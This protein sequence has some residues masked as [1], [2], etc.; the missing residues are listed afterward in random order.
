ME[1]S[2]EKDRTDTVCLCRSLA[3]NYVSLCTG[4][5]SRNSYLIHTINGNS[6]NRCSVP[7]LRY[8]LP[9]VAALPEPTAVKPENTEAPTAVQVTAEKP[10]IK[11]VG[12]LN[13]RRFPSNTSAVIGYFKKNKQ[14]ELLGKDVSGEWYLIANLTYPD[15]DNC[16]VFNGEVELSVDPSVV[17]VVSAARN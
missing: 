9:T 5:H 13:C 7:L 4:C 8:G 1:C 10:Q 17:P 14:T 15:R 16:W 6:T 3:G 2:N 11:S 12:N